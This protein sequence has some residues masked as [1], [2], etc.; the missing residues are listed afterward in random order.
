M[1]SLAA[2]VASHMDRARADLAELVTFPSV[3]GPGGERQ[4]AC[5]AAAEWVAGAF[6][7]AG[8]A[9][10][11]TVR[12][13]DS[14]LAVVGHQPGPPGTPTV[15]LYSH[16]DVQPSLGEELWSS[17][18]WTLTERDGR[19][20]GRGT[21]DCKG[22]VIMHLVALR[23]LA[24]EGG[25][26]CGVTVVV[27]GS[28]EFGGGGLE[29]LVR[30][31]P[32]LLAADAILIADSGNPEVGVPA[33]TTSLRGLTVVDVELRALAGD[34]HS[35]SFGGAAPDALVA[36]V[37]LLS[38]LH[39][40]RGDTTV[41]GIPNDQRWDG[42]TLDPDRF[43]AD[44]QLVDGAQLVGSG[45]V[46]DQAWARPSLTI[47]ALDATPR[48]R[49]INAVPAAAAARLALR[50]PPA[51]D[52]SA[53]EEALI[54]HLH[55][56]VPWGVQASIR[57]VERGDGFAS[58]PDGPA[59]EALRDALAHGAG[60][61]VMLLGEGGTIPLCAVLRDQYPDAELLLFG[62]QEP[63][64]RIHAPDESVDPAEIERT[65][66]AEA[67]FLRAYACAR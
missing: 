34:V 44:A 13:S 27:E 54:A 4:P 50:L 57:A 6:V 14:S 5:D 3:F 39:D 23:A 47:T 41:D 65:A 22:S 9:D 29:D 66:L 51:L 55:R 11:R 60:R 64:S 52:A 40:D 42:A 58:K 38:T 24:G 36:L 28:E 63:R 12:T 37:A 10:A 1:D 19:W 61:D 2:A 30:A 15:L 53:A 20:F 16:Y 67:R 17:P 45:S 32:G 8:I 21:A 25:L 62:V 49:A 48:A 18:P 7:A 35:G 46:A 26:P 31:E 59:F 33:V 43:R 56:R